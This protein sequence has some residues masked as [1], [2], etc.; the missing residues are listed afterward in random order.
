MT[1]DSSLLVRA[2][3][4]QLQAANFINQSLRDDRVNLLQVISDLRAQIATMRVD[5]RKE[6]A[7]SEP[8][9]DY[10]ID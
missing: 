9:D 8:A 7:L 1:V 5:R 4:S 2:L 6:I 3:E 10:S